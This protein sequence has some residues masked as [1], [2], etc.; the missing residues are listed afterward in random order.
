MILKF[1]RKDANLT[2]DQLAS[3]LGVNKSSIQKYE[4]DSVSNLKMATIRTLCNLFK[5]PPYVFIFPEL[6]QSE[7]D[8]KGVIC[9]DNLL[10]IV[11]LMQKLNP[12]GK[13]K[14]L[15]YIM[16]V[17]DSKKYNNDER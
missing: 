10:D 16:Y 13:E 3:I 1:L 7:K 8:L 12:Q 6:I 17:S 15:D 5:V 14:V 4:G 2:Q 11:L 9:D